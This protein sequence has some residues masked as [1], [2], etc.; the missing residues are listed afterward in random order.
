MAIRNPGQSY[1][2]EN[3]RGVFTDA[4]DKI[5]PG[6]KNIGMVTAGLWTDVNNDN[7]V[8]LM[9]VGEWMPI[10]LFLNRRREALS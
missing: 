8:D 4:T 2:L 6:L 5:A 7:Q 10:T 9:I 1:V 3:N